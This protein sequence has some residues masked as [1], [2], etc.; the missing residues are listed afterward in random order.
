MSIPLVPF[1]GRMSY[2]LIRSL[3]MVLAYHGQRYE[4]P[5]MECVSGQ[6]FEF[7]YVRGEQLHFTVIGDRYNLAGERLLRTLNYSYSHTGFASPDAAL[8]ALERA[9]RDGPVAVGMLDMG[10]LSYNPNH[11][12]LY[13]SDHAIV[14]LA[15]QPDSVVVHD[16]A[17]FVAVPLPLADFLEAWQRDVYTGKPYGLWQIGA[18]SQPPSD[19]EIWQKTIAYARSSLSRDK[20]MLGPGI[21]AIYG[22]DGMRA[23]AADLP[24]WPEP[25][26]GA[27]PYFSWQ[28]SA[29]RCI[30][31]AFF[32]RER[33]PEAAALRWEECQIYGSLQ[34]ASAAGQR[35]R[36]PALLTQLASLEERFIAAIG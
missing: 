21:E 27:L 18:Q 10:Y 31:S 6:A 33:L 12:Q 25:D 16:P 14:I 26:L 11:Q 9:L 23:L 2:C 20:Q 4:L 8:A 29:Q 3:H 5:W 1:A 28:V 34:Q 32:L 24:A 15:L 7:V 13:G 36:L 17:G 22:P 35:E 30:D 19:E